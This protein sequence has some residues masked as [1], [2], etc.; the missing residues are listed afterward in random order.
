M[1]FSDFDHECMALALELAARGMFT[2]HPNPRVGCV[3]ARDGRIVASG[4]HAA[5]GG[6]HA[7]IVALASAGAAASGATAYVTLEPCNHSGRTPPC[8]DALL[9][10]GIRR[11][12]MAI[13][14]PNS[15]VNGAGQ[16]R[17][18]AA[19]VTVECG[20]MAEAA[21]QLNAG[22]LMRMRA[23]R[24]WVRVK[25]ATSLDGRTAL[26]NGESRWISSAASRRDV[27]SWRA[28]ASAILTGIGTVLADDPAMTARVHEPPL[29]PLRII[30]D[31]H[32]RTPANS[33]I[34]S[35]RSSAL[36]AGSR[37]EAIPSALLGTGV[38]CLGLPLSAG[39]V[40]LHALL[41]HLAAFGINELQVEAG[42]GLC[43]ALL[44]AGL[45][46]EVLM[47][48]APVL[49]GEGGPGPFALGVLESMQQRM[50]LEVLES[51]KMGDDVRLRLRPLTIL[52]DGRQGEK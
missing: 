45:V 8:V 49:L 34:L 22:F 1:T 42:A 38:R 36:I 46:D 15:L 21:E 14:D 32:W 50:Q 40:D 5:T 24:P 29:L 7:E 28:R 43:G 6:P 30:A 31:T 33:R 4:W 37:E 10:A 35:D 9:E 52:R 44:K 47:Y 3:I 26:Q 20:L 18:E 25:I 23:A 39:R 19:G 48:L 12:V 27:Q 11:V 13:Q 17:L 16:R 51:C 41:R 2:A